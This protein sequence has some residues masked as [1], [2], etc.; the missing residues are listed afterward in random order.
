MRCQ[1]YSY[2][3]SRKASPLIGWYQIILLGDRG[4]CVLTTCPRLHSTAGRLGYKPT[5]YWS[6]VQ[7]PNH[8]ATEPHRFS[9]D[10]MKWYGVHRVQM[11]C[12]LLGVIGT[13]RPSAT[14][15]PQSPPLWMWWTPLWTLLHVVGYP[16]WF[17]SSPTNGFDVIGRQTHEDT[18]KQ[19]HRCALKADGL[20]CEHG[21]I[22]LYVQLTVG[23]RY[24][25]LVTRQPTGSTRTDETFLWR[26]CA[27]ELAIFHRCTRRVPRWGR[28]A[29]V[30][31]AER[32]YESVAL[33]L[34]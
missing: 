7:R 18:D 17:G 21:V 10:A 28:W 14:W 20:S 25:E 3:P 12:S 33:L 8:S 31:D 16:A 11:L 13:T 32:H 2:L 26:C 29:A 15:G 4:T 1:I 34:L 19:R 23:I 30:S 27:G 9:I 5:T 24:T 22:G 6:Q